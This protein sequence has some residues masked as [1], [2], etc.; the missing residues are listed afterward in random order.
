MLLSGP[1]EASGPPNCRA[2]FLISLA[3]A[4]SEY[5]N[6]Q[7]LDI[8]TNEPES[9]PSVKRLVTALVSSSVASFCLK[10]RLR[11]LWDLLFSFLFSNQSLFTLTRGYGAAGR[12]GGRGGTTDHSLELNL[13]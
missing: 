2:R 1:S 9:T 7:Q 3:L 5:Y 11:V 12:E 13:H 4:L 8:D 6:R 10:V